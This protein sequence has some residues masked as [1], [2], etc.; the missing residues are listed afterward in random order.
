MRMKSMRINLQSGSN[1]VIIEGNQ[2]TVVSG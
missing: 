1:Q 2:I